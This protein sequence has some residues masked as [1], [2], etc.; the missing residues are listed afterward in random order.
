M[1]SVLITLLAALLAID[2]T[3]GG[4]LLWQLLRRP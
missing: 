4:I 3:V 1:L 2:V